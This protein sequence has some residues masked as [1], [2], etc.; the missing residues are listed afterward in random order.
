MTLEVLTAQYSACSSTAPSPLLHPSGTTCIHLHSPLH[1]ILP[2]TTLEKNSEEKFFPR[3]HSFCVGLPDSPDLAA[4]AK[5]AASLGTIHHSYTY[6]IQEVTTPLLHYIALR[7]IALYL[8]YIVLCRTMSPSCMVLPLLFNLL[9]VSSTV[10]IIR[11]AHLKISISPP[12]SPCTSS[13]H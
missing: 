2:S 9:N 4:A 7:C 12:P 8:H 13:S 5:V 1:Y 10:L 3:L 11:I 6:T